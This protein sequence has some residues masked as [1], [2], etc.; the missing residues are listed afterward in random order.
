M[1]FKAIFGEVFHIVFEKFKLDK[2]CCVG[3]MLD[4]CSAN[5]LAL[6]TLTVYCEYAVG[7]RCMSHLLNNAGDKIES[8]QIDKFAGALH[9]L[10]SHSA[11]ASAQWRAVTKVG[12][13]KPPSHRWAST[14]DRNN[15]LVL[16]WQSMKKFIDDFTTNDETKSAKAAFLREELARIRPDGIH[17]EI[18]LQLEFALAVDL[19]IHLKTACYLLEGDTMLVGFIFLGGGN[20]W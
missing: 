13:P 11:N 9:M 2:R 16:N 18:A 3:F 10:L 6:D 20:F 15:A 1:D 19:G 7:I 12:P 14:Y 5:L 17:N 8:K 4:G